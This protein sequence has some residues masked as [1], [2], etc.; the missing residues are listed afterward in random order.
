[1]NNEKITNRQ[2]E[3]LMLRF[4][5]AARKYYNTAETLD[6]WI[7]VVCFIAWLTILLPS[8]GVWDTVALCISTI[9]D[10]AAFILFWQL[11]EHVKRASSLRAYF[12][13]YVLNIALDRYSQT[14]LRQL[15]E[16]ALDAEEQFPSEY[17]VQVAHT[18]HDTPPGVRDWYE[19]SLPCSGLLAIFTCQKQNCWWTEKVAHPGQ[20]VST[21]ITTCSLGLFILVAYAAWPEKSIWQIA[22]SAVAIILKVVERISSKFKYRHMSYQLTGAS[23]ALESNVTEAGILNFQKLI[24]ERRAIPVVESN[25]VHKLRAKVLSERYLKLTQ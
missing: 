14:E 16:W 11:S 8:G 3:E 25:L 13:A 6:I 18:G 9:M 15:E 7:W 1:M 12:D 10:I 24:D 17:A 4:Q 5:F 22:L 23:K 20:I 2:N 19:F 21:I